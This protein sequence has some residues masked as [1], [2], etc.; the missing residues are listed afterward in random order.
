MNRVSLNRRKPG[1][2]AKYRASRKRKDDA[3]ALKI[4]AK[5]DDRDGYCRLWNDMFLRDPYHR[6]DCDGPSEWAH[7]GEK[8][9]AK[10]RGMVPKER[11]TT[12][13][14]VKLCKVHHD[15]LDGRRRPRLTIRALTDKGADGPLEFT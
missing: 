15:R 8:T 4:R 6:G 1:P 10:T 13:D 9:R 12:A 3:Y 2:T 5:V 11:H 14:S 7:L